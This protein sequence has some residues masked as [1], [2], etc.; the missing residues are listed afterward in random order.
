MTEEST[1]RKRKHP[2]LWQSYL[3]WNE[4]MEMRKRHRLRIVHIEGGRS[5][6]D[7]EFEQ[8]VMDRIGLDQLIDDAKAEMQAHGE[9]V[10]PVWDWLVGIKGIGSHTAAKLLALFDDVGAYATISKF[11]MFSGWGLRD[12]RIVRCQRGEK[13][14]Y[15]RRLKAECFLVGESFIKQKT[16]VYREIYDAEKERQRRLHPAVVC[17]ECG[18]VWGECG[19]KR[20]HHKMFNDG[21]LHNRARR[22]M[23]KVF[24]SHLWQVWR[25]SEG[26]PVSEPYVQA[27]GGHQNIVAI[28]NW[29][30]GIASLRSQ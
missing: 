9:A 11:W 27:I 24:L 23:I 25:E 28:P 20:K 18:C 17:R 30:V 8:Y 6:L 1:A 3:L 29:P 12:G 10:G 4:L 22:K 19:S 7:A 5:N 15:N 16:P 26:L 13:S 14:P 2:L 21:H